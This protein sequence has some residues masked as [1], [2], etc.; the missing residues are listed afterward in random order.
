[1]WHA[2]E[3]EAALDAAAA[4]LDANFTRDD[5]LFRR[6]MLDTEIAANVE[7]VV[8]GQRGPERSRVA[9]SSRT[10]ELAGAGV[11]S[12]HAIACMNRA[13]A[14]Q[15][16]CTVPSSEQR[17]CCAAVALLQH[18][19]VNDRLEFNFRGPPPAAILLFESDADAAVGDV[20][21]HVC[22]AQAQSASCGLGLLL[23]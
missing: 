22:C 14:P 9:Y 16:N 19:M 6:A 20:Q 15:R 3:V 18:V 5:L 1:L 7:V 11:L 12:L 10:C 21:Q 4:L 23:S 13:S 2:R 8:S 17:M